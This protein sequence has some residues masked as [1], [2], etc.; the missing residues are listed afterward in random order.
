[1]SER[2]AVPAVAGLGLALLAVVVY[3]LDVPVWVRWFVGVA[4][5]LTAVL[6]VVGA[7]RR[8]TGGRG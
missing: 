2:P 7:L 4:V 5:L 8:R 6:L 1:V 3:R